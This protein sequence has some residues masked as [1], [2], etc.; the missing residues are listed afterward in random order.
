MQIKQSL[1]LSG[2]LQ[3]HFHF[4]RPRHYDWGV[5]GKVAGL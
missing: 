2:D 1:T 3:V 4:G 5:W